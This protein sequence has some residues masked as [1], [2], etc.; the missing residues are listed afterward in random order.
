MDLLPVTV[1]VAAPG[2]LCPLVGWLKSNLQLCGLPD[3][4]RVFEHHAALGFPEA[5]E[6][7]VGS[8]N[9]LSR[10]IHADPFRLEALRD[11]S[12][13]F[14]HVGANGILR[15]LRICVA[16]SFADVTGGPTEERHRPLY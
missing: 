3:P 6:C 5:A 14:V 8:G 11:V 7:S 1:V 15:V 12:A 9:G 13:Q 10:W 4:A 2:T 16:K